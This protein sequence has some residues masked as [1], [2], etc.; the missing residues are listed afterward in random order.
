MALSRGRKANT[1]YL[2]RPDHPEQ[3]DH[4]EHTDQALKPNDVS[5]LI[6][7]SRDHTAAIDHQTPEQ[8]VNDSE[9]ELLQSPATNREAGPVARA[10]ARRRSRERQLEKRRQGVGLAIGR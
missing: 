2:T 1:L 8:T 9:I 6:G 3:C 5:Q 10:I 7:R 4:I